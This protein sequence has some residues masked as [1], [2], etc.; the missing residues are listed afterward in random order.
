MKIILTIAGIICTGIGAGLYILLIKPSL[1]AKNIHKN[2]L[3]TSATLI[4]VGSSM[5]KGSEAYYWVK[6]SF[7]NAAGETITCKQA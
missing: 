4:D 5:S 3:E 1:D 6:L 7:V 2:G